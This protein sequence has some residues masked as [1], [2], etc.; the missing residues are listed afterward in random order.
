MISCSHKLPA[1]AILLFII[2]L[3]SLFSASPALPETSEARTALSEVIFAPVRQAAMVRGKTVRQNESQDSVYFQSSSQADSLYL[4]FP[5]PGVRDAATA[6]AGGY[7]IKRSLKDGKFVWLKIFVQNNAGS[8]VRLAPYGADPAEG[9]TKMDIYI[10]GAVFQQGVTVAQPF[11]WLLTAPFATIVGQTEGLVD[12]SIVLPPKRTSGDG[13]VERIVHALRARLK[14][15]RDIEDGAMDSSGK[16]VFI[17]TGRLQKGA[18]GFNCSG[19][20][21]FIVDGFTKPLLGTLSDIAVLKERN[22]DSRGNRWSEALEE[23]KDPYFGLDWSRNLA[24]TLDAARTGGPLPPVEF[25]DV[26]D[27][28]RFIYTEDVGYPM[29]NLQDVLYILARRDPGYFYIGSL[30]REAADGSPVRQ[31]HHIA[32]FFPYVDAKGILRIVVM[33]RNL[34]TSVSSLKATYPRDSVHL[35]R[36]D[37]EGEFKLP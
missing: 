19:F 6:A 27:V 3:S 10:D 8:Y 33:E 2:P 30:N 34:E 35:V 26:R 17:E 29:E 16:F 5:P 14:S 21:K 24:R 9:R 25:A 36:I 31:H 22:L 20:A 7:I 28:E 1:A 18:G 15:L 12:W 11:Q 4:I 37:A 23:A 32:V 13:R